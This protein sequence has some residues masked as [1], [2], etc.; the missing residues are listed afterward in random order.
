MAQSLGIVFDLFTMTR[1]YC[2]LHL[3]LTLV[4][5]SAFAQDSTIIYREPHVI[6]KLAPLSLLIDPDATLQGGLEVRTGLRSSVQA[7]V[8]FGHKGLSVTSDEKKNFANWSIWRV[9]SEWRH[10][11]NRYRT[12]NQKNVH[13]KSSFPLGNYV[14]I[15]GFA[16]QINGTKNIS[17]SNVNEVLITT[18]QTIHRFVWGSHVKWGRQIA[19]PGESITSLSRILL[20]FY[21]GIGIRYGTTDLNPA[22]NHCGCGILPDRFQQGRSILPSMTAGIKIG[23]GL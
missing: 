6:L 19:I 11:T 21:I 3:V 14:A 1:L 2:F 23:V 15:E 12:N 18:P 22:T 9:R 5:V 10:Y 13:I 20:D 8:G 7:E 4:S 16:K 17:E